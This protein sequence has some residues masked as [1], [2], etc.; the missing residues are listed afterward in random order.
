MPGVLEGTRVLDMASMWATPLAGAYL[1]DQGAD[2]IKVEPIWGDNAR[3]TFTSPPMANEESRAWP[4]VGRGKRGIALNISCPEG[5]EVIYRLVRTSD[6]LLTNF[7]L[8]AARR[9]GYDYETLQAINPRLVYVRVGAYGDS[10][11]YAERRG[12]DRLLQALSGM[13]SQMVPDGPPLSAGVWAADMSTPWAVCYGIC[14][15]LL[16]RERTGQG[17]TVETSLL[18][19]A[20]S[21]QA[22][23]L[24]RAETES[25]SEAERNEYANQ[26]LFSP[27]QCR[28]GLWINLIVL[29]DGEFTSLCEALEAPHL[30]KDPMF[31]APLDRAKSSQVLYELLS[32]LFATRTREEWLDALFRHDV[33]CAPTL[34]RNEVFGSSQISSNEMMV[35]LPHPEVGETEMVNVPVRLGDRPGKVWRRAP[36]L[37]EH[38]EEVLGEVGY[39]P[40]EIAAMK[41]NSTAR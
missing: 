13:M 5:Q 32:G 30:S 24:V 8:E 38:T 28:D 1:A 29:S 19:M 15:A 39:S 11:P 12:Y 7:R 25:L 6:V 26:A 36:L 23:D 20:L 14:L 27:Y 18:H 16:D 40:E 22:V 31:A 9:L 21:M 35:R 10:G 37:G 3:R 33:P 2:V 41:R 34:S 17:Q 4:M